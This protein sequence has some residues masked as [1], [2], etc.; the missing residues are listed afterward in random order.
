MKRTFTQTATRTITLSREIVVEFPS[1]AHPDSIDPKAL[2]SALARADVE[3]E[4]ENEEFDLDGTEWADADDDD[5]PDVV[6]EE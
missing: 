1:D 5:D 4:I 2:D 3:W 6:Y